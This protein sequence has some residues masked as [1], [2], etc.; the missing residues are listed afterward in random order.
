MQQEQTF[1][2][3]RPA[4]VCGS[5][6]VGT[7]SSR[8]ACPWEPNL[9][10]LLYGC[11]VTSTHTARQQPAVELRP[12]AGDPADGGHGRLSTLP[13]L[14]GLRWNAAL[15]V[16]LYHVSVVQYF[17]GHPAQQINWAFGA[18]NIGV[19]FFFVLSGFV[20][21]WSTSPT[22][23]AA[24]FWRRRF[25][26][27]YPLH[28]VTALLALA[29]G[30]AV[31]P[32]AMP[33][34]AQIAANLFMIHSWIPNVA[35]YQ[36][37]NTV[38]WSLACEAFFYFL[39]PLLIR[40]LRPLGWQGNSVV[41]AGCIILEFL[42]PKLAGHSLPITSLNFYLYYFP[43]ARLPEF[44][45]GM[46]LAQVVLAGR[47]RGPGL[48]VSM[49]FTVVSYFFTYR[50]HP[51]YRYEACT[52]I[53]IACLIAAAALA[54][55]RGEP[56]PWRSKRAVRLGELSFAFYMIH[57][58]VMRTGEYVFYSHPQEG[59]LLGSVATVAAFTTSLSA[60]W[61]LNRYVEVPFRRIIL[62]SPTRRPQ[63]TGQVE[64]RDVTPLGH[65]GEAA[66]QRAP[67]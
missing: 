31:A 54:D 30:F 12:T 8:R 7:Q 34:F 59:W 23:R 35:F 13:S 3:L 67:G 61:V 51:E 18:G 27:V 65:A 64:S 39:F 55:V 36:S 56:S 43:L 57:L 20:L 25:A 28:F 41:I 5:T 53:G 14:T 66:Q 63:P 16:F 44:L 21:S 38:S 9:N 60:A 32:G 52:V 47:W 29:L 33:D 6:L 58:L 10:T 26:R 45:L 24:R 48:A 19:S 4:C 42:I 22:T 1:P 62:S 2:G 46:A 40:L 49:A 17:G 15:L 50:V 11:N 37:L